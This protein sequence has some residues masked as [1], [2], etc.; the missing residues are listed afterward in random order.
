MGIAKDKLT[1]EQK[2]EVEQ[3]RQFVARNR[4]TGR[5]NSTQWRAAIDAVAAVEGYVPA[6]RLKKVTDVAEPPAEGWLGGFPAGLPLYNSI[7]W[8]DL[9][10]LVEL[11]GP[12]KP[13]DRR[14]DFGPALKQALEAARIPVAEV[15][16]GIRILAYDR[17][18]RK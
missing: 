7:E 10:G 17:A 11:P 14:K 5:I 12:G 9:R 16:G 13:R 15:P 4:L 8:L 1:E 3:L 2:R 6:Y 18:A